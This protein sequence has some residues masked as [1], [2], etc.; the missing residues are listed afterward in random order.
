M[1]SALQ[2]DFG[3]SFQSPTET[4]I[5]LIART[6]PVSIRLGGLAIL[7][8]LRC[9]FI[10]KPWFWF[11]PPRRAQKTIHNNDKVPCCRRLKCSER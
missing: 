3:I 8:A 11:I 9:P 7:V 10:L 2:G 5:Q 1:G 6:W 4:V